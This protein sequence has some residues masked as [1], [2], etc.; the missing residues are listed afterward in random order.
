MTFNIY[1][2][3]YWYVFLLVCCIPVTSVYAQ[4]AD[5]GISFGAYG[6]QTAYTDN[7]A[8]LLTRVFVRHDW[9]KQT[10]GEFN[11]GLGSVAGVEYRTRLIPIEYRYVYR[12]PDMGS[13]WIDA[14]NPEVFAG[15]GALYYQPL[16]VAR[17][18]DPLTRE[19]GPSLGSS[20]YWKYQD[21]IKPVVPIGAS[22]DFR[23]D[24]TTALQV[25]LQYN[26]S[27]KQSVTVTSDRFMQGYWGLTVGIHFL[28][29]EP[30]P[31][32]PV[33]Q[34][35]RP[36]P[37]PEKPMAMVLPEANSMRAWAR[38]EI[39]RDTVFF[40]Y[41]KSEIRSVQ[42]D[43]V[44]QIAFLMKSYPE[45]K[46]TLAGHTDSRGFQWFNLPLSKERAW[47]VSKYI[48]TRGIEP[49]RLTHTGY[50]E[51]RPYYDNDTEEGR[52]KNR[53]VTFATA[54][55]DQKEGQE[56]DQRLAT[57]SYDSTLFARAIDIPFESQSEDYDADVDSTFDQI[58]VN[59]RRDQYLEINVS[60]Y[61]SR[62]GKD[63]SRLFWANRRAEVIRLELMKRGID[64]ERIHITYIDLSELGDITTFDKAIIQRTD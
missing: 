39:E 23:L 58:A 3:R 19:A 12:L 7:R 46:L 44:D 34:I 4:Q 30:K 57:L 31:Q 40:D 37:V 14:L 13:K 55:R 25:G 29:P 54:I 21:G 42:R 11:I 16:E 17:P 28:K 33:I 62:I 50:G 2:S 64:Y 18:D 26:Q 56:T 36:E 59:M 43:K 8:S 20:N 41:F 49:G 15:V 22:V 53:R 47:S 9:T 35:F 51:A 6:G 27:F 38:S 5:F 48:M 10:F 61:P 52:S 1:T 32:P 24:K 60:G 45:L 63:R